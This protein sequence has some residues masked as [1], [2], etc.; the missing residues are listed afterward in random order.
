MFSK[1]LSVLGYLIQTH[2]LLL[3]CHGERPK[4]VRPSHQMKK[5]LLP[6][7]VR[8]N[9]MLF[10]GFVIVCFFRRSFYFFLLLFYCMTFTVFSFTETID[11]I[12]AVINDQVITLTDIRAARAFG[13]Y[14]EEIKGKQ[15]RAPSFILEQL[16]DQKLVIQLSSKEIRIDKQEVEADLKK[17]RELMG[18]KRIQKTLT[19]FGF[20]LNDLKKYIHQK[21]LFQELIGRKFGQSV[22][23]RLDEIENYYQRTY[24]PS[25]RAKGLEPQ[26]M[27]EI[28]Q[29]IESRIR[30][31]KIKKQVK[32]WLKNLRNQADIQIKIGNLDEYFKKE[33][34]KIG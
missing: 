15:A 10:N 27:I 18:D 29:E 1:L 33:G 13:L 34:N 30:E 23:V 8:R 22:V 4:G 12:V 24:L 9:D 17:I 25:Q 26:P 19:E 6:Q 21:I 28:L 2:L 16:I 7:F 5:R 11:R 31:N 32:Q 14:D 3:D 20:S